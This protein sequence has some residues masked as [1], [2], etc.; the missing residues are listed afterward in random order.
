MGLSIILNRSYCRKDLDMSESTVAIIGS[1]IVGSIIAYLMTRRGIDVTVFEKGPEYPYPHKK[2]FYEWSR[3][4]FEDPVYDPPEGIQ[5]LTRTGN[6]PRNPDVERS[7]RVGGS[8]TRWEAITLRFHPEDFR[9]R[10]LYGFDEDW[11]I[12]YEDIEPYYCKAE[13]LLGVSGTDNDNPFAPSRS[14]NYPL[15][16]F[17]LSYGDKILADRLKKRGIVLHTT[18]QARTRR[19]Y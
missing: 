13:S 15:P 9:T 2:Q 11:P 14:T 16:P 19:R 6:Y 5:G 12:T 3:Y 4:L 18:P 10:S 8:A 1:G 7:I 17:S